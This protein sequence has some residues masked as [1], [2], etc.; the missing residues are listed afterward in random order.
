[1][2]KL[3]DKVFCFRCKSE[4]NHE[5]L[6]KY[7][8]KYSH[9]DKGELLDIYN[10]IR[11]LGCDEI[12]FLH[13][14]GPENKPDYMHFEAYHH[15]PEETKNLKPIPG[16]KVVVNKEFNYVPKHILELYDEVITAQNMDLLIL[17]SAGIRTLIEAVCIELGIEKGKLYNNDGSVKNH[18]KGNLKGTPII[19]SSLEGKIYSL[20]EKGYLVW[21]QANI[22]QRVRDIGNKAVHE[23]EVPPRKNIRKSIAII[24]HVLE[25][26]YEL[27][28]YRIDD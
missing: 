4:T 7:K 6:M 21:E 13:I 3:E 16:F 28:K 23:I 11:C 17:C 27:H 20:F 24:E 18:S 10:T 26:I 9:H 1:M 12:A 15:F 14:Y 19:S 2:E 5:V 22:L 8:Q 25:I